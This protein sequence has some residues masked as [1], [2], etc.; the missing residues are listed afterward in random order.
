[1]NQNHSTIIPKFLPDISTPWIID[2]VKM[3]FPGMICFFILETYLCDHHPK[4]HCH[5]VSHDYCVL[6][7][8]V[9]N[10][11]KRVQS[12]NKCRGTTTNHRRGGTTTNR[13]TNAWSAREGRDFSWPSTYMTIGKQESA[14]GSV[15]RATVSF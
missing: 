1:M 15:G 4:E 8:V 11:S 3:P 6:I 9:L 13:S 14:L 10:S 2:V 7:F 5:D 12:N